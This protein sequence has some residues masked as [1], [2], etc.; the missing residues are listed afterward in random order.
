MTGT[1][2]HYSSG[3]FVPTWA[4]RRGSTVYPLGERPLAI[5]R[6]SDADVALSGLDV[7]R[8]HACV[9]PTPDGPML[10]DR[11]RLGTRVNRERIIA[12][13]VLVEGDE[14]GVGRHRLM[15]ERV[16]LD[17]VLIPAGKPGL[18]SKLRGWL[19][20]YGPS[21][22]LGTLVTVGVTTGVQQF[23]GSTILAA[24]AGT[25][26]EVVV[27]YGVMILRETVREAYEAGKQQLPYGVPQVLAVMRNLMLEFGLAEAL[28]SGLL[29]PVCLGL[30]LQLIGGQL[31]VLVGK[32]VADLAFYGPVLAIYEW[33][34]AR[35]AGAASTIPLD[36]ERRTTTEVVRPDESM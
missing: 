16:A 30:G 6:L 3:P 20:R 35:R 26:A 12:P 2:M 8:L 29:R 17:Q 1:T 10:V 15:L 21:E 9:V 36:R 22:V 31:G 32:L 11:S 28:D 33:R 5:G 14:I 18:G 25:L 24:Y 7:S 27:Y 19:R 34:M 23:T 13:R 4:L